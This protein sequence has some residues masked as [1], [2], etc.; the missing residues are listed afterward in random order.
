[1]IR[2]PILGRRAFLMGAA[3]LGSLAAS[4]LPV[5]AQSADVPAAP[6]L[7]TREHFVIRG[8]YVLSMDP[9][10]GELPRGDV[11]VRD[12]RIVA[13]GT[14]IAAPGASVID[15]ADTVVLPGLVE[16]HWHLWN[17]LLRG[18]IGEKPNQFYF[19][20]SGALGRVFNPG[21]VYQGVRLST[22]EA[23]YGGVTTVTD[24]SHNNQTR[25]HS[26]ANIR[27]IA[28][29]GIR[30]R[31]LYGPYMGQPNTQSSNMAE[32]ERFHNEW[33][34]YAN[35]GLITLGLSWRANLLGSFRGQGGGSA[36][37][38]ANMAELKVARRLKLP[39]SVHAA[40]SA[41]RGGEI[42][43]LGEADALGKDTLLAHGAGARPDEIK[44]MAETKTPISTTPTGEA[45]MG[46]PLQ[47][48]EN[49]L[50]AGVTVG[51]GF[52]SIALSGNADMFRTMKM[53]Q[54]TEKIRNQAQFKI[55]SR[56]VLEL[57]TIGGAR[58]L[59]L[60][61]QIGSLTPGKRA[62]LIMVS[63]LAPNMAVGPDPANL[64]VNSAAPA[65]VE[66]V[67]VD[68][69]ILKRDGRLTHIDTKRALH[70]AAA[71]LKAVRERANWPG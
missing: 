25:A 68:G 8:G 22:I 6:Q 18:M 27:A 58:C 55:S 45:S 20:M 14:N 7:P 2:K 60:E 5:S 41:A 16:T 53:V 28:D 54:D 65:N 44:L 38:E 17:T 62:D 9:A 33:A 67:V 51:L 66:L 64:L 69:R 56:R 3:S 21:D 4:G 50:S 49:F 12:G 71:S 1:M 40:S 57:V 61:N 30:A 42:A 37:V 29:A 47:Q 46:Y 36:A 15:A 35:E 10:V 34:R 31:Y 59:G 39:I 11:H 26:E 48:I 24:W 23:L 70:Q 32:L 63:L 13:V 43:A 19:A 52:D